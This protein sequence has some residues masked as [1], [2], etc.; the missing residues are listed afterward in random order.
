MIA[1]NPLLQSDDEDPI[2][3][4]LAEPVSAS[5]LNTFHSC[6]LKF[7]YRYVMKLK[8]PSSPALQLGKA[9][10]SVL[11]EW[12]KR[13]WLG[14]PADAATLQE[15]FLGHWA[16]GLEESHVEF[17]AGEEEQEQAKAWSVVEMYLRDT[18][19]PL[20]EKPEAVEVAATADLSLHGLPTL[21]GIIDLIRPNGLIVDFKTAASTP[22]LEQANHRNELQLSVYGLLYRE[23][24]NSDESG[25]EVHHLIKTKVPKLV[26]SHTPPMTEAQ[27][28]RLFLSIESYLAGVQRE[29][30][31]PSPGLQCASCEFFQECRGGVL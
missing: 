26:V 24:T 14:K 5:R 3:R 31:I 4:V 1:V 10:H 25:F 2:K 15:G 13:R 21:Y 29:D 9:V 7:Y 11:Q 20:D 23:A 30:W 17:K 28:T 8:K 27:E 22:C 6:R 19:I 18:P 12:S 16:K